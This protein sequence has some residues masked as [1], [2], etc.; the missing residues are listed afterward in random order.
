MSL[1]KSFIS[2]ALV[3]ILASIIILQYHGATKAE[4]RAQAAEATAQDLEKQL[5]EFAQV[6]AQREAAAQARYEG[7][8]QESANLRSILSKGSQRKV[9]TALQNAQPTQSQ[10][11]TAALATPQASPAQP[12]AQAACE[13]FIYQDKPLV[14]EDFQVQVCANQPMVQ[15]EAAVG[16]HEAKA[17]IDKLDTQL[18]DDTAKLALE[19]KELA[20]YKTAEEKWKKAAHKSR[21]KKVLGVAEKVGLFAAGVYLGH[22]F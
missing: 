8:M 20:A 19:D 15:A 3:V 12:S 2:W 18:A 6:S 5:H 11:I 4:Q 10:A 17:L 13:P 22:R 21:I 16:L 14:I 1:P 9:V 7:A